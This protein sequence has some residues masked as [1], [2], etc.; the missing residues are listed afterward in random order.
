MVARES[1]ELSPTC[2][3]R[4]GGGPEPFGYGDGQAYHIYRVFADKRACYA[5]S[6]REILESVFR[7]LRSRSTWRAFDQFA[8]AIQKLYLQHCTDPRRTV[9]YDGAVHVLRDF[10]KEMAE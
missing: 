9:M 3:S 4:K 1:F 5:Y 8:S 10:V 2:Q 6:L 7:A